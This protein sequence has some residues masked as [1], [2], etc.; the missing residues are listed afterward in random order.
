[1]SITFGVTLY[2]MTNEWLAGEYTLAGMVDEVGRR[3]IGPGVEVVGFQSFRGSL[4]GSKRKSSGRS[5]QRWKGTGSRR[6][7][8]GEMRT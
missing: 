5:V 4:T 1:M 2:S 8:W 6:H 3:G 7:A